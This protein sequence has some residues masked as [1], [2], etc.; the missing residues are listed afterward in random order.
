MIGLKSTL[1]PLALLAM[2]GIQANAGLIT[3]GGFETGDLTG[4]TVNNLSSDPWQVDSSTSFHNSDLPHSG[5]FFV[6]TGC[7]GAQCI[8]GTASQQ[9]SLSQDLT[10]IV[11]DSYTLDFFFGTGVGNGTPN[12]LQ[13]LFGG[14]VVEDLVNIG[15]TAYTEY[16]IPNLV[17]TSTTTTLEFLG[18]QDPGWDEL[19]D[20]TVVDN[21]AAGAAPE[22][23]SWILGFGI[24]AAFAGFQGLS[25]I[26]SMAPSGK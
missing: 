11:G 13:A 20:I 26:R 12:E 8:N 14:V 5:T 9:A 25:R 7:V 6:S 23:A 18:R 19:D 15:A 3:N 24:L 1:I 21:T 17:A 22:P 2:A 4:W 10:T 16:K